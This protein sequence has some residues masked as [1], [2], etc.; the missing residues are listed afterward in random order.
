MPQVEI[1]CWVWV[2]YYYW[3]AC[4]RLCWLDGQALPPAPLRF[5]SPYGTDAH[6]CVKRDTAWS[7]YRTH[8]TETCTSDLPEVMVHVAT[9]IAPVQDGELTD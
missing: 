6:Y 3:D 2:H 5:D 8:F 1:L 9:T 4:G 7:G